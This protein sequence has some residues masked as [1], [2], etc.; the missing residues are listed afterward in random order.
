MFLK[1]FIKRTFWSTVFLLSFFLIFNKVYINAQTENS[2]SENQ[3]YKGWIT[4]SGVLF[5]LEMDNFKETD[6]KEL[7]LVDKE[8]NVTIL[9]GSPTAELRDQVNKQ[10]TIT[11]VIKPEMM[12]KGRPYRVI[13]ARFIDYIENKEGADSEKVQ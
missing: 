1:K 7:A 5:F 3:E 8:G 10:I 2:Y 4:V 12:V 11:G 6:W 13:E 9:I